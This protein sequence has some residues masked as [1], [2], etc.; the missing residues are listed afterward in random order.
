MGVLEEVQVGSRHGL[1]S[2]PRLGP[3]CT[4]S[5][6]VRCNDRNENSKHNRQA[7]ITS[8]K[9]ERSL[10]YF[11]HKSPGNVINIG[12]VQ[13]RLPIRKF[14]IAFFVRS[15]DG[16]LS[17]FGCTRNETWRPSSAPFWRL[18]LGRNCPP[19]NAYASYPPMLCLYYEQFLNGTSAHNRPFQ[20]LCYD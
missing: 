15:F 10:E 11:I 8:N 17:F 7:V 14:V 16:Y 5:E 4:A 1:G 3:E 9:R 18:V 13:P 19:P 12:F 6:S 2:G 20:C